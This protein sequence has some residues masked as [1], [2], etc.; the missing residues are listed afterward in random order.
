MRAAILALLLGGCGDE[1]LAGITPVIPVHYC[2]GTPAE[3]VALWQAAMDEWEGQ[4]G[5][6]L[7]TEQPG[8]CVLTICARPARG[9]LRAQYE[10]DHCTPRIW[11]EPATLFVTRQ[12]E[13]GHALGLEHAPGGTME[14]GI[15]TQNVVTPADAERVKARWGFE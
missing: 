15:A 5:A 14:Q 11:Y 8:E 2:A 10:P 9:D 12:H 6:E 4:V 3:D 1:G 13:L 7:F